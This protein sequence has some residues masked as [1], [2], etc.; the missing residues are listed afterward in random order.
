MGY[1]IKGQPPEAAL[2]EVDF[3]HGLEKEAGIASHAFLRVRPGSESYPAASRPLKEPNVPL[4][5][6]SAGPAK[7]LPHSYGG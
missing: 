5:Y 4:L 6:G 1:N 3:P 7:A 2:I